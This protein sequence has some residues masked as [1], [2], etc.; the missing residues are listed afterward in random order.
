MKIKVG[1]KCTYDEITGVFS[2][3]DNNIN[4][5]AT[6]KIIKIKKD[7]YGQMIWLEKVSDLWNIDNF[8]IIFRSVG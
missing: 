6:Y 3:E 5:D 2:K 1:D 8:K 4:K 7:K